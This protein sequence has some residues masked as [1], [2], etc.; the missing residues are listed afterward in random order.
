[1]FTPDGD[2][3]HDERRSAGTPQDIEVV[4]DNRPGALAALGQVLGQAGVSLDGG[5]VFSTGATATAHFLVSDASAASSALEQAGISPVHIN[6]VVMVR[7]D[8]DTP[9]Q[10]GLFAQLMGEAGVN[11]TV[12]YSDH[13]GNLVIVVDAAQYAECSRLAAMWGGAGRGGELMQAGLP[14]GPERLDLDGGARPV[15]LLY[16]EVADELTGTG[17]TGHIGHTRLLGQGEIGDAVE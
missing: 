9:G 15:A 7:L 8:Q 14:H 11:I 17:L 6:D 1:M 3:R 5:G 13:A 2:A 16:Q 10:L 4:L 12:Q